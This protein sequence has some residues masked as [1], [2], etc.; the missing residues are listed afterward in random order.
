MT[1]SIVKD[2]LRAEYFD[3]LPDIRSATEELETR[4][5]YAVL[6]HL[7][8]RDEHELITIT[9]R[10]KECESAIGSIERRQEG[11]YFDESLVHQYTLTSLKDL[12][13]V[14]ILVFPN[15]KVAE[16]DD[17]LRQTFCDWTSDPIPE[18]G[19]S[20]QL[21]AHKYYGYCDSN[22][23]VMAEYQIVPMLIGLFWEVEYTAMYKPVPRLRR[24]A[25]S[26]EMQEKKEVVYS[27][28]KAFTEEFENLLGQ[29]LPV[30]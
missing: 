10:V 1:R 18:S 19:D 26:L 15:S 23:G 9:S 27:A 6:P 8:D 11:R 4:I 30:E 29:E 14:R 7:V 2:K 21:L 5:R 25:R 20:Q 28:L 13:G 17:T 24:I 3:L 22:K 12:A 16:L